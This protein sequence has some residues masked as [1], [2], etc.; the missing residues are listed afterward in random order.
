MDCQEGF[1]NGEVKKPNQKVMVLCFILEAT[2]SSPEN[3]HGLELEV[4]TLIWKHIRK[5]LVLGKHQQLL[6][7]LNKQYSPFENGAFMQHVVAVSE[8]R[9]GIL[10]V[11]SRAILSRPLL[12]KRPY[13]QVC[14]NFGLTIR[15]PYFSDWGGPGSDPSEVAASSVWRAVECSQKPCHESCW[16]TY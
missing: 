3:F 8:E 16:S 15:R 6:Q 2:V 1:A 9:W 14:F 12:R 11:C 4:V 5:F 13:F 10:E 7:K